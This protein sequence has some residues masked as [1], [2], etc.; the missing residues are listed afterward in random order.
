MLNSTMTTSHNTFSAGFKGEFRQFLAIAKGL[1]AEL[2]SQLYRAVDLKYIS[3]K[4]FNELYSLS[5]EVSKMITG[6]MRYLNTTPIKGSK[7]KL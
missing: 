6:L 3:Q 7:Y 1:S 5:D 2:R 4:K